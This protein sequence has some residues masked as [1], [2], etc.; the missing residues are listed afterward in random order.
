M[1]RVLATIFEILS[2]TMLFLFGQIISTVRETRK[3][4]LFIILF[5]SIGV[6]L[7]K[8][9]EEGAIR[10]MVKYYSSRQKE[11]FFGCLTVLA[12]CIVFFGAYAISH[13]ICNSTHQVLVL[14]LNAVFA[15]VYHLEM[16]TYFDKTI[17]N[18]YSTIIFAFKNG[19]GPI[20]EE[21]DEDGYFDEE[22][23]EEAEYEEGDYEDNE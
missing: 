1:K 18:H 15:T 16:S 21:M 17:A 10:L 13:C 14:V 19:F 4:V 12:F 23:D 8:F 3:S 11:I 22:D 6:I 2:I 5:V 7:C 20:L 9:I